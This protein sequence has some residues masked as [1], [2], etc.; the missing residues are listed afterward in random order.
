MYEVV[1]ENSNGKRFTFGPSGC[2]HFAINMAEGMEITLGKSQGFAQI[3]ETVETQSVSGRHIDVTGELYGNIVERKNALRNTCAPLASG[4]LVFNG[5]HYIRVYV[6]AAPSF[7]VVK[8]NG[9]FKMQF[10]APFPFFYEFTESYFRIGG[11]VKNFRFPVNYAKPHRFG[12]RQ[13]ARYVNIINPGDVRVPFRM[14]IRSEGVSS[15]ATITNLT[16]FAYLKIN[17]S[18]N[19]GEYITIYR[20]ENNVLRAELTSGDTVTDVITWL[21]DDSSLFELESG[22]NLISANDDQGGA[23]LVVSIAFNPAVGVLYES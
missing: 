20:D 7:S 18:L 2:S 1:F 15:N 13:S 21:D 8:N 6:K 10:Y 14:V 22:D 19:T 17:G 5:T 4:R 11:M 16:T 12:T 3:G 23:A 9:L